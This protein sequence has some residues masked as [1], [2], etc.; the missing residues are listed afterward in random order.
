M[1]HSG[2]HAQPQYC[3]FCND[4]FMLGWV[5]GISTDVANPSRAHFCLVC[6]PGHWPSLTTIGVSGC[7]FVFKHEDGH[8]CK[9]IS[10]R[11]VYSTMPMAPLCTLAV[12]LC[13][14]DRVGGVELYFL[15]FQVLNDGSVCFC[16]SYLSPLELSV[17]PG[18]M[19][20]A[21]TCI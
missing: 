3:V 4:L 11:R 14:R 1:S 16:T 10:A 7:L 2:H 12:C 8:V 18:Q 19:G 9:E 6:S 21:E 15:V 5:G 20:G 13:Q 17:V